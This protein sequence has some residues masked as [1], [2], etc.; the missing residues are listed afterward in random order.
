MNSMPCVVLCINH[1]HW[2]LWPCFLR[3]VGH[4]GGR[5]AYLY[6]WRL[7]QCWS[8]S[9]RSTRRVRQKRVRVS[10][11]MLGV[12]MLQFRVITGCGFLKLIY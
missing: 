10:S 1:T 3:G 7:T 9:D 4:A 5:C 8:T 12:W 11:A 2:V 6:K